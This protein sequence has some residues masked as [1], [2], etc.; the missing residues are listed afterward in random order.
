MM[1]TVTV[2][3][4][5]E[6][7]RANPQLE[8]L[9]VRSPAE[10]DEVHVSFARN[11]PLDQ[12]RP[13]ELVAAGNGRRERP[14]YVICRSG[15]RSQMAAERILATGFDGVFNVEGGTQAAVEAGLPVIRS[16][17]RVM[18]IENQVRATAGALVVTGVAVGFWHWSGLVLAGLVG[19]GLVFAGLTD[20]CGMGLILM[21]MP[22]NRKK[23][24]DSKGGGR[25]GGA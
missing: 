7:Q 4:L 14:L 24:C 10:F 9:D 3:E 12:L 8:L 11:I 5:A 18:S 25:V 23:S 6:L 1:K 15:K 20:T 22:W 17:S 21:Q 2:R 13:A 16:G 19:G